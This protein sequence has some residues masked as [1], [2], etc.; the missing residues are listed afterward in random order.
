MTKIKTY[1][2]LRNAFKEA[3]RKYQYSSGSI[4]EYNATLK[5]LQEYLT[6][7]NNTTSIYQELKIL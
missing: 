3:Q 4:R 2:E 6:S 7:V 5:E 1:L